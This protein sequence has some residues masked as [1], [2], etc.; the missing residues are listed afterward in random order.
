VGGS[1]AQLNLGV[2][3]RRRLHVIGTVL[4]SRDREEKLALTEKVR[5]ELVPL[6]ESGELEPV[7]DRVFPLRE[8]ADAHVYMEE[9]RNA[10]KVVL[11]VRD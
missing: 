8:A 10:G 7:V 1:I 11:R 5:T 2:L 3:L 6:F 9:N 4:R